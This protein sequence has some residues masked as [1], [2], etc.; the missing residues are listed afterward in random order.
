[1]LQGTAVYLDRLDSGY[2]VETDSLAGHPIPGR[3]QRPAQVIEASITAGFLRSLDVAIR[4]G[5]TCTAATSP[6]SHTI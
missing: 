4:D 2:P 6:D 5:Q 1:M 3:G